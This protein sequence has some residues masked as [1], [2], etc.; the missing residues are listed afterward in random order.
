MGGSGLPS[1]IRTFTDIAQGLK[2]VIEVGSLQRLRRELTK[3]GP[4]V[5][6][7]PGGVQI[8]RM[9]EAMI[10][11]AQGGVVDRRG[12]RLFKLDDIG[13]LSQAF[14]NGVWATEG[15]REVID[16]RTGKKSTGTI[17]F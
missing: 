6:G 7:V 9:T 2:D 3:W 15:G 14:L 1:P 13:D 16:R 10:A 4:G 8:S 5:F 17:V 12:K 11:Y